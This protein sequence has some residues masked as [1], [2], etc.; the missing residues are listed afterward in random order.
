MSEF[1]VAETAEGR[2]LAE[3]ARRV[4]SP[5]A[6]AREQSDR[7]NDAPPRSADALRNPLTNYPKPPFKRQR[8]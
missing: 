8:D 7:L 2:R 1:T 5:F 6:R 3:D 4:A